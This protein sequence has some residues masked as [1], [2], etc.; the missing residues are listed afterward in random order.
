M[1]AWFSGKW[2][3]QKKKQM[4]DFESL[5]SD[6]SLAWGK[7]KEVRF[8]KKGEKIIRFLWG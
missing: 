1:A 7:I 6:Y 8:K 5:E 3:C 2:Q 4:T